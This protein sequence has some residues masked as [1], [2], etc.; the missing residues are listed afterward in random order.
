[1][2]IGEHQAN[3]ALEDVEAFLERMNVRG[4][5]TTDQ[6][7]DALAEVDRAELA[8]RHRE[9]PVA[10][11]VVLV[12]RGNVHQRRI[13]MRDVVRHDHCLPSRDAG[14][15]NIFSLRVQGGGRSSGGGRGWASSEGPGPASRSSSG[16]PGSRISRR[17]RG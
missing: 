9:I 3:G 8:T 17:S 16:S 4:Q 14:A 7:A 15:Y 2:A 1:P 10:L 6:F 5:D 11:A 12:T 13:E